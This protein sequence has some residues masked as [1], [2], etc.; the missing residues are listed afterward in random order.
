MD[1]MTH[2]NDSKIPMIAA[3]F[4]VMK[5]SATTVGETAG[6]LLSMTLN[7]GYA[8]S[9]LIVVSV[10]FISLVAQLTNKTFAA[11]VSAKTVT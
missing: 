8:V 2:D 6:D 4:G 10:F 1:G 7:V 9:S 11:T 5:I 3:A